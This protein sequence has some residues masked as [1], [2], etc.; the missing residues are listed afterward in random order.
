MAT[1]LDPSSG[2]GINEINITPFVDVV[3]VLLVIFMVA[4]PI[5]VKESLNVKLP[6]AGSSDSS[7]ASQFGIS[8]NKRDQ[9]LLNGKPVSLETLKKEASIAHT[10]DRKVRALISAD[11]ESKHGSVVSVIDA[12]KQSGIDNFA[13]QIERTTND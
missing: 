8:I 11:K 5:M 10:L 7:Q 3:L 9:I 4:A 12:V 1:N 2:E 6:K 13:F